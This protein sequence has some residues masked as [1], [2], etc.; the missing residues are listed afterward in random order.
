MCDGEL[1]DVKFLASVSALLVEGVDLADS[2][3][4]ASFGFTEVNTSTFAHD[5]F[6]GFTTEMHKDR[7]GNV[8]LE[9]FEKI[10]S[11]FL[12]FPHVKLSVVVVVNTFEDGLNLTLSRDSEARKGGHLG[13]EGDSH[14]GGDKDGSDA[15]LHDVVVN[16]LN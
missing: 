3:L 13:V 16:L 5:V 11:S 6:T 7:C 10:L 1:S 14:G 9:G 15:G 4:Q 12:H 8:I 2:T